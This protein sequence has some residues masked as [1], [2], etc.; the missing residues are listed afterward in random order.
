MRAVAHKDFACSQG[1]VLEQSIMSLNMKVMGLST[2]VACSPLFTAFCERRCSA[3]PPGRTR[4]LVCMDTLERQHS[5]QGVV[6][7][8]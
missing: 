1:L 3:L 6:Q 2:E 5:L 4:L 7:V 8:A